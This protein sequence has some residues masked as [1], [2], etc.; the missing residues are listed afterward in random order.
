M[1][2]KLFTA[3]A[4]QLYIKEKYLLQRSSYLSLSQTGAKNLG[5]RSPSIPAPK[6]LGE[7]I[8]CIGDENLN[9]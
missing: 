4:P 8:P 5:D 3:S 9:K 1:H 7:Y 6:L 2:Q